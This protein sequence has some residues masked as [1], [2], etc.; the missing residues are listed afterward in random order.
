MRLIKNESFWRGSFYFL[1]VGSFLAMLIWNFSYTPRHDDLNVWTKFFPNLNASE[2]KFNFDFLFQQFA[3]W[4]VGPADGR[5]F[6]KVYK[7]FIAEYV[8][9]PVFNIWNALCF[10]LLIYAYIF[11][12][13]IKSYKR[14]ILTYAVIAMMLFLYCPYFGTALIDK[15]FAISNLFPSILMLY[16]VGIIVRDSSGGSR[17]EAC[18]EPRL[19]EFK[20]AKIKTS[21]ISL[22]MFALGAIAFNNFYMLGALVFIIS[23][24]FYSRKKLSLA[25]CFGILG[26]TLGYAIYLASPAT[27]GRQTLEGGDPGWSFFGMVFNSLKNLYVYFIKTGALKML[28]IALLVLLAMVIYLYVAN[29]GRGRSRIIAVA[30]FGA[31]LSFAAQMPINA[32]GAITN[33]ARNTP[34]VFFIFMI[35]FAFALGDVFDAKLDAKL[36]RNKLAIILLLV[37]L[38]FNFSVRAPLIA[39]DFQRYSAYCEYGLAEIKKAKRENKK[40][41]TL[42]KLNAINSAKLFIGNF[43]D[44]GSYF[45]NNP[46][47]HRSYNDGRNVAARYYGMER[48]EID[49]KHGYFK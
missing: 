41:V 43:N 7:A 28:G 39:H 27:W 9:I 10:P 32:S 13:N 37:F 35:A 24:A 8:S 2:I 36:W 3:E 23:F 22:A 25:S 46:F 21:L 40:E 14:K 33:L 44:D 5:V 49:L 17:S 48:I 15:T 31:F 30:L 26:A 19:T 1:V 6:I 18:P 20:R 47:V 4:G 34:Y 11:M 29:N 45:G 42:K 12:V 16:F 38:G